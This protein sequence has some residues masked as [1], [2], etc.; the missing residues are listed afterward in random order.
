VA[1]GPRFDLPSPDAD[2]QPWWDAARE[3][4][5][6]V[7]RCAACGKAHFYPRPFC[8]HCWSDEV[9]WEEASGRATLYTW[10]VVHRND[11]PPFNT[12]VPYVAAVVELEEGPRMMTNVVDCD[13]D[14]LSVDM[15]LT[16]VFRPLDDEFTVPVFAPAAIA[17]TR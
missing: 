7:K 14:T 13:P 3:H 5:L 15:P 2:T 17:A 10:S 6:L 12:R 4:R 9:D 11:L 1:D 16:V 8:P